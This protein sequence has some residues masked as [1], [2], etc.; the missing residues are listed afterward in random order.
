[1]KKY[2]IFEIT[3]VKNELITPMWIHD[4]IVLKMMSEKSGIGVDNILKRF[5]EKLEDILGLMLL[6]NIHIKKV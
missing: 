6:H 3:C 2:N 5:D 1:M 4:A